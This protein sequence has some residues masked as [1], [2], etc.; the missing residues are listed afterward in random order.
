MVR[1]MIYSDVC[2]RIRELRLRRGLTQTDLAAILGVSKSVISSYENAI[3]MPPYDILIRLSGIF[4]VTCDYLLGIDHGEHIS[5]D[6]LTE[7][8]IR[9]IE[10]IVHELKQVNQ[11]KEQ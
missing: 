4:G 1:E 7:I 10:S 6:G 3:H 8:Q 5:T 9:A 2:K 11:S